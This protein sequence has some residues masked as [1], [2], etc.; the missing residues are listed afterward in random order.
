MQAHVI[1][2]QQ[3]RQVIDNICSEIFAIAAFT[4]VALEKDLQAQ[5]RTQCFSQ[6]L[7]VLLAVFSLEPAKH[8]E[9]EAVSKTGLSLI[10]QPDTSKGKS[11]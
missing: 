9:E 6:G 2:T 1:T 5:I 4:G 11:P 7:P 8:N 10:L 3:R